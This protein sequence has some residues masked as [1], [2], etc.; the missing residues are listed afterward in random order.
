MNEEKQE[1]AEKRNRAVKVESAKGHDIWI[2][3]EQRDGVFEETTFGLLGE[4]QG[5]LARTGQEG[6][7][8]A[9]VLGSSLESE[10]GSPLTTVLQ[11]SV[12]PE[13]FNL[14]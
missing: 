7:V 8:T 10:L 12:Y 14:L 2:L 1:I 3:A 11:E 5:V 6:K 4:A 13:D 9:V